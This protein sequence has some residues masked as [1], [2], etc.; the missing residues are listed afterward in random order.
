LGFLIILSFGSYYF[1][2]LQ[3]EIIL[4]R[5][6][7]NLFDYK[8]PPDTIV[9]DNE[10]YGGANWIDGGGSG[11]YW[12]VVAIMKLSTKLSKKQVLEYYKDVRFSYSKSDEPGK[13]EPEIY[14]EDNYK[15]VVYEEG[16]Y[17]RSKDDTINFVSSMK[18]QNNDKS[19]I[20]FLQITDGY[21]YFFHLD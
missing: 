13:V 10:K 5:F 12:N 4:N 20:Y 18:N 7:N 2:V 21:D 19:T 6:S 15:K 17:Y 1:G 9:L 16:V 8:L 14:F 11:G 3:H